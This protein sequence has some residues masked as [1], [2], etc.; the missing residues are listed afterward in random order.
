M[1]NMDTK[2][3]RIVKN[4]AMESLAYTKSC[5]DKLKERHKP[6]QRRKAGMLPCTGREGASVSHQPAGRM[7]TLPQIAWP[8]KWGGRLPC[9]PGYAEFAG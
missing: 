9:S 1:K 2:K 6:K 3:D 4:I 5:V 7:C 8:S